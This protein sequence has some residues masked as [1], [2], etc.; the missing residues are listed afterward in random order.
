MSIKIQKGNVKIGQ[1]QDWSPSVDW[2]QLEEPNDNEI[3]LLASDINPYY[4]FYVEVIGGY[5]VDWGDGTIENFELISTHT[6]EEGTGKGCSR[7]YTTFKIRIYAQIPSNSIKI[8]SIDKPFDIQNTRNGLLIAKIGATGLTSQSYAFSRHN[9]ASSDKLYNYSTYLEY[10]QYPENLIDNNSFYQSFYNC[11]SLKKI[12][13]PKNYSSQAISFY[14][15][16][17]HCDLLDNVD[18]NCLS[19]NIS[20]MESAFSYNYSLTNIKLPNIINSCTSFR[21]MFSFCFNL[22]NFK[23]PIINVPTTIQEMFAYNYSLETL[24]FND[25][26]N[27]KISYSGGAFLVCSSLS[28]LIMYTESSSYNILDMFNGTTKLREITFPTIT[29]TIQYSHR[30]FSYNYMLKTI[31]N[32]PD[33]SASTNIPEMFR[34][35]YRL[36][37]IYGTDGN[38]YNWNL[39]GD[40]TSNMDNTYTFSGCYSLNPVGGLKNINKN[41]GRFVINGVNNTSRASLESLIFTNPSSISTWDGSSPQIDVA[42]CSMN[43]TSLN[44]LFT[45]IIATSVSFS[46]KTIRITGNPGANTCDTTIITN[47]GGTVN[48]TT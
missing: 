1:S 5:T 27:G 10:I 44:T 25:S 15:S 16:F 24:E 11:I 43:E 36:T 41:T 6:Y 20:T 28:N 8:F 37:N 13:L 46:G 9:M 4:S 14:Q 47:A 18:F 48:K 38:P 2:I 7:G 42:Y 17:F 19:L 45:S 23:F 31:Y 40:S 39:L 12:K 33:L 3:L 30:V 35:C 21:T 26:N 34:N 32:M 22:K 29:S